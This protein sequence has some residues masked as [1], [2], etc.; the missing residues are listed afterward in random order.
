[1]N[2][3]AKSIASLPTPLTKAKYRLVFKGSM[4]HPMCA[5]S[6]EVEMVVP[7]DDFRSLEQ[8]LAMAVGLLEQ[9]RA[10]LNHTGVVTGIEDWTARCD[11]FLAHVKGNVE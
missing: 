4:F 8:R 11:A 10:A 6:G 2:D 7:A 1:M 3:L 9:A 5:Y